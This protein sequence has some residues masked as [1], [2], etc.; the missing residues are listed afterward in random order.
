MQAI[1]ALG[2][3]WWF[4]AMLAR[5]LFKENTL[6]NVLI[7]IGYGFFIGCLFIYM[8]CYISSIFSQFYFNQALLFLLSINVFLSYILYK[9]KLAT[10]S[11]IKKSFKNLNNDSRV[12]IKIIVLITAVWLII[13]LISIG[14]EIL[15]Q[16]LIPW[17]A[18]TSWLAK[19]KFWFFSNK[20]LAMTDYWNWIG[21]DEMAKEIY[22]HGSAGER[23]FLSYMTLWVARAVGRWE[24]SISLLPWLLAVIAYIFCYTGQLLKLGAPLILIIISVLALLAIP[25]FN[26]HA[27]L[28]GYADLW[29]SLLVS[30]GIISLY[31]WSVNKGYSHVILCIL[32]ILECYLVKS[33]SGAVWAL[34]LL[35][36]LM[37]SFIK[38]NTKKIILTIVILCLLLI[39]AFLIG[40]DI[41]DASGLQLIISKD[42]LK[43]P[44]LFNSNLP[45]LDDIIN[46]ISVII[47]NLFILGNWGM[48]WYVLLVFF[49]F[50]LKSV[51]SYVPISIMLYMAFSM[52][53]IL[54]YVLMVNYISVSIETVIN[55]AYLHVVPSFIYVM[56][57]LYSRSNLN[58]IKTNK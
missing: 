49:I 48:F 38:I 23:S 26:S 56:T 37:V 19:A 13:R 12:S 30:L 4:G 43:I 6:E 10:I 29:V 34:L 57:I 17:D 24:E 35:T 15:M 31:N 54:F 5:L 58:F 52:F 7:A 47:D 42:Q 50:K 8:A 2:L 9:N 44:Y 25:I 33:Q 11:I 53:I 40:V 14:F 41:G 39:M 46:R 18:Y 55:R 1:L 36:A 45:N 51:V 16:P 32:A 21:K 27:A 20:I 28:P 3:P 22:I